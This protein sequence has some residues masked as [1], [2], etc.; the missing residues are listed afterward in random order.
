M[1]ILH[2][3]RN[4]ANQAGYV[5]AGLR[6]LGH[7]AEVWEYGSNPF[8]FP[9]DRTI[10]VRPHEPQ[11][12][13]DTFLAAIDRFDVFHFHFGR[14]L[15]P[16]QWEGLPP[17]WD[18]PVYRALG[19]RLFFTFHGSDCRIRR[20]HEQVNPWS[21][22]RFADVPADDD[23]TRKTIEIIR[24][25][26]DRMFVTSPDYLAFVPEATVL[27]RAID[28][29][30][31]PEQPPNQR[32]TPQIV[33][34]PSMRGT[35]GTSFILDGLAALSSGGTP[36][37]FRLLE[38]LPHDEIRTA[39]QEADIVI[40][41]VLT[42]DYELVSIEAMASSR[43][44]VANMQRTALDTFPDAPVYSIDPTTFVERMRAL[45]E[46]VSNRR[47]LA[48][49]GR[50]YVAKVHD[51]NVIATSLVSFYEAPPAR[52]PR[53]SFPDW[54]SLDDARRIERL[55]ARIATLEQSLASTRGSATGAGLRRILRRVQ[56]TATSRLR[57]PK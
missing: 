2:A 18:L 27:P 13:W 39:V 51:A 1:R 33:H 11:I 15:F 3:P 4:V 5:A 9:V 35:K 22:Y 48:A 42:G 16:N 19:K 57:R 28:L 56:T 38:G 8:G 54:A 17:L 47:R 7:D 49:A 25:Y 34:A 50:G 12:Y 55:E 14:S 31:W 44:A 32:T 26:A 40:D 30:S 21:Y 23:R 41:N 36:F 52:A 20:I 46:D 53:R 43:V 6:R 10:E 29:A 24:T 37:E 45:I